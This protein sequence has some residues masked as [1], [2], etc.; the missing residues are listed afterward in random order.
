MTEEERLNHCYVGDGVYAER[1]PH[2]IILRTGSHRDS[3]CDNTIY[4]DSKV[5]ENFIGWLE[6]LE[7]M[8]SKKNE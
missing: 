3:E 4:L 1:T 6:H 2:N 8:D 5:L 7:I